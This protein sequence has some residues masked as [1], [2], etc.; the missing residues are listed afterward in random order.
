MGLAEKIKMLIEW[1][2][3]FQLLT[4]LAAA[5]PGRSRAAVVLRL[6][7]FMARKTDTPTDDEV[8]RLVQNML[9]TPE[10]GALVDYVA[11][12]LRALS[13]LANEAP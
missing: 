6:M 8:V 3:V 5:A 2:P 11:E 7:E 10:G 9:L 4:E 13:E 1:S 12:K